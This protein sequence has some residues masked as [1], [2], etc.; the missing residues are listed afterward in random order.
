MA[1]HLQPISKLYPDIF[2][3]LHLPVSTNQTMIGILSTESTRIL[4][5]QAP[6]KIPLKK[7]KKRE[8]FEEYSIQILSF[9]SIDQFNSLKIISKETIIYSGDAIECAFFP[10]ERFPFTFINHF[11]SSQSNDFFF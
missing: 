4:T 10:G 5:Y 2:S 6:V 11:F 8:S 3:E 9:Y 7:C 1:S